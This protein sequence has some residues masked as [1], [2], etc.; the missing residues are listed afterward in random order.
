LFTQEKK[1]YLEIFDDID[2]DVSRFV[3][4]QLYRMLGEDHYGAFDLLGE[5]VKVKQLKIK[6]I[7]S[8]HNFILSYPMDFY[9]YGNLP[10]TKVLFFINH[11]LASLPVPTHDR[12]KR[13]SGLIQPG[14]FESKTIHHT[15]HQTH[16]RLMLTT[17]VPRLSSYSEAFKLLNEMLGASSES[18]LFKIVREEEGLCYSI[19]SSFNYDHSVFIISMGLDKD[20][21]PLAQKRIKDI[22]SMLQTGNFELHWFD[23][24]K[25]TLINEITIEMDHPN[26]RHNILLNNYINDNFTSPEDIIQKIKAVSK[27]DIITVAQMLKPLKELI[28]LGKK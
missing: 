26:T 2:T 22:I 24:I 23:K 1:Q 7:Q 15:F 8:A 13:Q 10:L 14:N 5:K 28:V 20:K 6:D 4:R 11:Y 18:L 25:Q 12:P 19:R 9:Y 16:Y 3:S 21:V 27:I 17:A